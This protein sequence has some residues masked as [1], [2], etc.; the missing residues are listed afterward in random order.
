[1]HGE[2]PIQIRIVIRIL[3]VHALLQSLHLLTV[4]SGALWHRVSLFHSLALLRC[5]CFSR[6]RCIFATRSPSRLLRGGR[7]VRTSAASPAP[8]WRPAAGVAAACWRCPGAQVAVALLPNT[9]CPISS[10]G[11]S[12]TQIAAQHHRLLAMMWLHHNQ[13]R[14]VCGVLLSTVVPT[15][16]GRPA[17]YAM[18]SLFAGSR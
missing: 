4:Q 3:G 9:P 11:G 16:D 10:A 17:G 1:M 6:I 13:R 2:L 8:S 14:R 15:I 18:L 7:S 5:C 12:R